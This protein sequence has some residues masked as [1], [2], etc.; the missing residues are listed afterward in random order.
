MFGKLIFLVGYMAPTVT[1]V[2]ENDASSMRS[3]TF[4]SWV[5]TL[6]S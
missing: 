2:G 3:T 6:A 4:K 5:D 1:S